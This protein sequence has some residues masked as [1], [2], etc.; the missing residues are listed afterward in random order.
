VN[1]NHYSIG[2]SIILLI[3]S[4]ASKLS[5]PVSLMS[6]S[7]IPSGKQ[8]SFT[9]LLLSHSYCFT[10]KYCVL[11]F[12]KTV[13]LSHY[14]SCGSTPMIKNSSNNLVTLISSGGD[15]STDLLTTFYNVY[16]YYPIDCDGECIPLRVPVL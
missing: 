6:L 15:S 16:F 11:G 12:A 5:Y 4:F 3:L 14:I 10:C 2:F 13:A 1:T 9:T 8:K 7:S